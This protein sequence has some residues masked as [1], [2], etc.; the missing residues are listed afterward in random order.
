M[1]ISKDHAVS[2][3]YEVRNSRSELLDS[4]SQGGAPMAYIHGYSSIIPG[5][6]KALE[7]KTAGEQLDVVVSPV[8]AYGLRDERRM[9]EVPRD[10]F[11]AGAE[12][13]PGMR[14]RAQRDDGTDNVMVISVTDTTVTV[15]ANHPLAGETLTF[16]VTVR[17]VR[18]ATPEEIAHGHVHHAHS[19]ADDECCGGGGGGGCGCH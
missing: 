8:E 1:K 6:E 3:D 7:G 12:I 5:L 16:N 15:D 11:P 10:V 4:S 14:F 19:H 13:K 17:D 9:A 2:F 18:A